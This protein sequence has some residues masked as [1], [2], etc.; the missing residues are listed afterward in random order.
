MLSHMILARVAKKA[1]AAI[2]ASI[3]RLI[4][5]LRTAVTSKPKGEAVQQQ[6]ERHEDMIKSTLRTIALLAKAEGVDNAPNFQEFI[7]ATCLAPPLGEKYAA[8]NK[9]LAERQ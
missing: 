4:D 7:T 8:V 6:I 3:E 2:V 5:P 9:E 1:P